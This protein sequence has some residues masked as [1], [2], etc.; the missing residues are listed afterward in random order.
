M[1]IF[2]LK[3]RVLTWRISPPSV[4]SYAKASSSAK[5]NGATRGELDEASRHKAE[6]RYLNFYEIHS[7]QSASD[8]QGPASFH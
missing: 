4:A 1:P 6:A 5:E 3:G 2:I 8:A 7:E